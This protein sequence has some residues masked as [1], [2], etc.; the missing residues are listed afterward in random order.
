MMMMKEVNELKMIKENVKL[1]YY[2]Y[3]NYYY[4]YYY[5]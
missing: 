3:Y 2:Y 1:L 4:Y 5:Y